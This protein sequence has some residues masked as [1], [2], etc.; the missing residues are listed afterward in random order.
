MAHII[1]IFCEGP[2][3]VAFVYRMLKSIAYKSYDKCKIGDLPVPFNQLITREIE[4]SEVEKLNLIEVR[5][6]F[7]PAKVMWKEDKYIFMYSLG[8]DS[9]S[10]TRQKMIKDILP[11]ISKP[12]EIPS[13]PEGTSFSVIYL[14]DSDDMGV[15]AR[16]NALNQEVNTILKEKETLNLTVNGSFQTIHQIIFGAYV[17]TG[18][19]NNTGTL[20]SILLPLMKDKNETIFDEAESFVDMN[21]DPAHLFPLKIKIDLVTKLA[22][23][24]RSDKSKEKYKFYKSKS[25]IGTVGQLQCSG[26]SNVVCISDSDYITVDKIQKNPKCI[27]IVAFLNKI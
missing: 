24:K 23:E 13:I 4:K 25:I 8:G 2:H 14:F 20:E 21:H 12:N 19:D 5:R 26:K 16:L 11:F 3:D 27:E 17:F 15:E 6:G 7:L 22:K 1:T 18:T 9:K 10:A